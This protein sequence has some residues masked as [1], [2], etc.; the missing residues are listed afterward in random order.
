M[1]LVYFNSE[2][3]GEITKDAD[4]YPMLQ[5]GSVKSIKFSLN[6]GEYLHKTNEVVG[7]PGYA[8]LVASELELIEQDY[9]DL[10]KME[11]KIYR[12][13]LKK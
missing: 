8:F 5:L 11:N 6:K 12:D 7:R 9:M 2:Y 4:F 1:R 13:I 10:R 3:S